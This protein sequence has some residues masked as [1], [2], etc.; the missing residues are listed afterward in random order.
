MSQTVQ[1]QTNE[2]S[3]WLLF[4]GVVIGIVGAI[5]RK[6]AENV[7][8]FLAALGSRAVTSNPMTTAPADWGL[9]LLI[10]GAVVTLAWL[11]PGIAA[12]SP[13]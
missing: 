11:I 7:G 13:K 1:R 2:M 6:H 10:L 4:S 3:V 5:V 9:G 8:E 12:P